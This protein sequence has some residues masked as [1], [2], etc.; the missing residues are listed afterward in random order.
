MNLSHLSFLQ[1]KG[2]WTKWEKTFV[3]PIKHKTM[4]A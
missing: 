2:E 1:K 4:H 3:I